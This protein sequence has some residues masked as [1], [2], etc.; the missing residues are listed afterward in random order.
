VFI[1]GV[2]LKILELEM[3]KATLYPKERGPLVSLLDKLKNNPAWKCVLD[4]VEKD[5]AHTHC[6]LTLDVEGENHFANQQALTR[7]QDVVNILNLYLASLRASSYQSI[8][9]LGQPTIARDQFV[10]GELVKRCRLFCG[11]SFRPHPRVTRIIGYI[12]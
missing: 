7:G 12:R 9:I 3:G 6:Y 1:E 8:G 4:D 5:A 10:L 2:K 11:G